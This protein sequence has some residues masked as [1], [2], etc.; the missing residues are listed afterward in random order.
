[1]PP[2]RKA[3]RA[4]RPAHALS[5]EDLVAAAAPLFAARGHDG[6]SLREVAERA[7]IRKASLLHHFES[8]EA[9]YTAVVDE[10]L[11]SLSSLIVEARLDEGDYVERLDRLGELVE[12]A[13]AARPETSRLLV[14]E[15]IG[16]GPYLQEGGAERV[17]ATLELTAAFLEAGME[18]G[19]FR[20]C[21]PRQLAVSIAGLH[22][23]P[24]AAARAT[25]GLLGADLFSV[26]QSAL[27]S[28][29][30]LAQVRA[31]CGVNAGRS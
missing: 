28:R 5:R 11:T 18:A 25:S 8:K 30:V 16:D 17:Q 29:A 21:D 1:M 7:G 3:R 6:V 13:L 19:A 27:R 26:E 24:F 22:L 2:R 23:F 14:Y 12:K 10:A 15:L 4:G 31:L 20:R 9:L